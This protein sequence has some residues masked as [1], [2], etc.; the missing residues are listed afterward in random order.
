MFPYSTSCTKGNLRKQD[1]TYLTVNQIFT[2]Q[3]PNGL[4]VKSYKLLYDCQIQ[5]LKARPTKRSSLKQNHQIRMNH[6]RPYRFLISK[7]NI[8]TIFIKTYTVKSLHIS[9]YFSNLV[10]GLRREQ[11]LPLVQPQYGSLDAMQFLYTQTDAQCFS[12]LLQR[13]IPV[14]KTKQKKIW[15]IKIYRDRE[16]WLWD[17]TLVSYSH[18][19]FLS[20]FALNSTRLKRES[21]FPL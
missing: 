8:L 18:L 7:W 6:T 4:I 20:S 17:W 19:T 1:T 14:N 11:V 2:D 5:S 9:L 13:T 21:L 16:K 3:E 12:M 15:F 10:P